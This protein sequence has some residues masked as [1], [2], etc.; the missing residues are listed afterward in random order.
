MEIGIGDFRFYMDLEI[1]DESFQDN[2]GPGGVPK[3]VGTDIVSNS[4]DF[5]PVPERCRKG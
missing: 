3:A 1:L 5:L 2:G 4:F